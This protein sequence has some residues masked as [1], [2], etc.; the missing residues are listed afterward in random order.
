MSFTID[1][2]S[3]DGLRL[4]YRFWIELGSPARFHNR[5]T[6]E[7]WEVGMRKHKKWFERYEDFK[8]FLI[9]LLRPDEPNGARLGNDFTARN[10]RMARDPMASFIKQFDVAFAIWEEKRETILPLLLAKREE[11][12]ESVATVQ[13]DVADVPHAADTL[14]TSDEQPTRWRDLYDEPLFWVEHMEA[15]DARFPMH[16]PL[17][18]ET[19][20]QWID[21]EFAPLHD[22]DWRCPDCGFGGS[23]SPV[24]ERTA[25]CTECAEERLMYAIEDEEWIYEKVESASC[26]TPEWA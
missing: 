12:E 25:W 24:A 19:L 8:W 5:K 6:L 15:L 9:W 17:I 4:A 14:D 21:R 22:P 18:G 10:L 26:L 1:T 7:A 13:L 3:S 23:T 20:D 16:H 11:E 2:S